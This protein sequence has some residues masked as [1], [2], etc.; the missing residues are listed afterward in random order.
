MKRT[1]GRD[2]TQRG[3][4]GGT[5]HK[6]DGGERHHTKRTVGRGSRSKAN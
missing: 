2:I 5:S 6:K 1:V 3:W 4:W